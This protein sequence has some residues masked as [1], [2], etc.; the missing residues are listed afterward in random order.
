[1]QFIV[2][3][4]KNVDFFDSTLNDSSSKNV[5]IMFVDQH[6]YYRDVFFFIDKLKNLKKS[7]FDLK[8]KKYIFHCFK[9]ETQKWTFSE[10]IELKKFFFRD[11]SIDQ[12][13]FVL[14]KRFKKRTIVA[15]KNLQNERF[16]YVDIRNDKTS[17]VYVQNV[18]RYVKATEYFFYLL[19]VFQRLKQF[20][21]WFSKADIRIYF[22]HDV[23]RIFQRFER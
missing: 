14:I 13:C 3:F 9:S 18:L 8:I 23:N 11:V 16:I 19:S 2:R 15:M 12:W 7:F 1:M 10:L 17:R 4:S 20:W 5:D 21:A 6:I 22:S